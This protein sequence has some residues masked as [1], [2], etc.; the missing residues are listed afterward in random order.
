MKKVLV[1]RVT[2]KDGRAVEDDA[3]TISDKFFGTYGDRVTV[4]SGY[5]ACSF[6]KLVL[7]NDYGNELNA[8][9]SA[10]GVLDV[11]IPI[12]LDR[13]RQNVIVTAARRAVYD[14]L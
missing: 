13:S 4:K 6:G 1:V 2:D 3:T 11:D 10:P 12:E 9:M 5:K 7:T 14:A 8:V